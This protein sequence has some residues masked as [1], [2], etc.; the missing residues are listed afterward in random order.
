VCALEADLRIGSDRETSSF[1]RSGRK[2]LALDQFATMATSMALTK[3]LAERSIAS[4][5]SSS[6]SLNLLADRVIY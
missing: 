2:A 5:S 1:C 4:S 3:H 6:S